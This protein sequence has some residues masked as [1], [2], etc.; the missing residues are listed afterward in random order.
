[1][2]FKTCVDLEWYARY[3]FLEVIKDNAEWKDEKMVHLLES[4]SAF[5]I[6]GNRGPMIFSGNEFRENIGTTGG[7]I[8][9]EK[10]DFRFGNN[11]YIVLAENTFTKNMAYW[12]GN[13]FHIQ[14]TMRMVHSG[15]TVNDAWQTC[16]N[17]ILLVDNFFN[18]NIGM[19]RHNGGAGVI[20]CEH[21][22]NT[23][24]TVF[25]YLS[26]KQRGMHR[27][28]IYDIRKNVVSNITHIDDPPTNK[29]TLVDLFDVDRSY[30]L[31]AYGTLIANNTFANNYSGM[32]GS[33]L[34]IELISEVQVIGNKF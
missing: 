26:G 16:G 20:R 33:A 2:Q 21:T 30:E 4:V 31:L 5:V 25:D 7:V 23:L 27:D 9:I 17:G 29:T 34:L 19:K 10:P 3:F 24:T 14:M 12:A 1:M 22:T 8:H 13:A 32:R 18:G 11:P 15:G 28:I 6:K